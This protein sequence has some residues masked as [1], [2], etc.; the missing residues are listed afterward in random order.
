MTVMFG[1]PVS[2]Q[3]A[4]ADKQSPHSNG[5]KRDLVL[6]LMVLVPS[7]PSGLKCSGPWLLHGYLQTLDTD[8]Q[9]NAF[10]LG[11][12]HVQGNTFRIFQ[13][14]SGRTGIA[15]GSARLCHEVDTGKVGHVIQVIDIACHVYLVYTQATDFY[16]TGL[17]AVG[18]VPKQQSPSTH[19]TANQQ[20][21]LGLVDDEGP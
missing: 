12:L 8:G 3:A 18:I 4:L 14:D 15:Q 11:R 6:L 19:V 1:L 20:H 10:C 5:V 13:P 2:A 17:E 9:G 21:D 7:L 16:T